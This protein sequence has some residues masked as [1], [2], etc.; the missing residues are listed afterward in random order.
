MT[1]E[2]TSLH[3]GSP[4]NATA[5]PTAFISAAAFRVPNYSGEK[6]TWIDHAPFAFWLVAAQRPAL[7]VEIN[8]GVADSYFALCQAV[9]TSKLDCRCRA[10]GSD[11][12]ST[13]IAATDYNELHYSGFS[14]L[15]DRPGAWPGSE[16]AGL[17][18]DL[19]HLANFHDDEPARKAFEEWLPRLSRT[20]VV[21]VHNINAPDHAAGVGRLWAEL[22]QRYPHFAFNHADGLGVLL[23]GDRG[24]ERIEALMRAAADPVLTEDIRWMH[25]RLGG[26]IS[27]PARARARLEE[28]ERQLAEQGGQMVILRAQ[29]ES[30]L[31]ALRQQD[32]TAAVVARRTAERDEAQRLATAFAAERDAALA[33]HRAAEAARVEALAAHQAATAAQEAAM[34]ERDKAFLAR[35]T[36]ANELAALLASTSWRVTRPLRGVVALFK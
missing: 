33:T 17:A 31:R 28:V 25:A 27:A 18:I 29:V 24:G 7:I 8:S 1:V 36:V 20:A 32:Y 15:I 11:G 2:Q 23:V 4:A 3:S 16:Q 21:L 14:R 10:I 30:T 13:S 22:A 6:S 34:I 5:D 19:L 35:D 9:Q 26:S 12:G